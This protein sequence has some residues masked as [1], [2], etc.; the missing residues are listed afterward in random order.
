MIYN[1][2]LPQ[3]IINLIGEWANIEIET[4][5]YKNAIRLKKVEYKC[6]WCDKYK[7]HREIEVLTEQ[8]HIY[9]ISDYRI[10]CGKGAIKD[11]CI[12]FHQ[13]P[14]RGYMGKAHDN[15]MQNNMMHVFGTDNETVLRELKIKQRLKK[16]QIHL[17]CLFDGIRSH[18]AYNY[19]FIHYMWQYESYFF[20]PHSHEIIRKLY[21][22]IDE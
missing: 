22:R 13:C 15:F 17:K 3:D 7:D 1:T 10:H 11:Q 21:N 4:K 18:R 12:F 2:Q 8:S 19:G 6:M 9:L 14:T 16:F 5:H 20:K